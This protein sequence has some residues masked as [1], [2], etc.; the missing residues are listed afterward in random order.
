MVKRLPTSIKDRYA[1]LE[2]YKKLSELNEFRR[3]K[4]AVRNALNHH[5]ELER[6]RGHAAS[7]RLHT[8]AHT[9]ARMR[10]L[11]NTIRKVNPDYYPGYVHD[12]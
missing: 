12:H 5:L 9:Y 6:L 8:L 7:Q 11:F 10:E 4:M 2:N 1:A 3:R